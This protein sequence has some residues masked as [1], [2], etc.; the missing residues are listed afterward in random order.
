MELR[1]LRSFVSVAREGNVT[2]AAT[3]LHI[4]QPAL[5]RQLAE[6]ER[7]LGCQLLVRESRGVTLT[8]EG[9]VLRRR[10]EE[11]LSLAERTEQEVGSTTRAL[12]GD[13][14]IG[15][16]ES[17]A[18]M[19]VARVCA[20]ISSE[21][22][23][24]SVHLH[25]G[26]RHD[27]LERVEGGL[28]DFGVVFGEVSAS[29]FESMPLDF[30]ETWGVLMPRDHPLA[31]AT[32]LALEDLRGQR[33]IVSEETSPQQGGRHTISRTSLKERGLDVFSTY[34]LLY[35][36]SLLVEA[37]AGVALCFKD[38]VRTGPDTPFA[39]VPLEGMEPERPQ[40]VWK[41]MTPTSRVTSIFLEYLREETKGTVS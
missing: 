35:N 6:L 12:E 30:E 1:T 11:I 32:S 38:I 8:E 7:E 19:C 25:S 18:L 23:K 24:V 26:N 14:W 17:R 21:H 39:F 40:I 3:S 20:R 4:T 41:R 16:G 10:A 22:P 5:S 28:C 27:V 13:L 37:K 2:R 29:S 33:L 31:S 9:R 15:C 36:A 34:T